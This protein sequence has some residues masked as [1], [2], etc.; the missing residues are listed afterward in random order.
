[1]CDPSNGRTVGTSELLW[2]V[3]SIQVYLPKS[4]MLLTL[5]SSELING[6]QADW[7]TVEVGG[8][9]EGS[10]VELES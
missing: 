6:A 1:M 7:V 4:S 2:T 10:K 3:M 9:L 8:P 5:M